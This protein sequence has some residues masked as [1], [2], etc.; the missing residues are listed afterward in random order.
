MAKPQKISDF[1]SLKGRLTFS[2]DSPVAKQAAAKA[3][4]KAPEVSKKEEKDRGL[5]VGQKVVL[6]DSDLRGRIVSLGRS[7]GIELEDGLTIQ[8]AYGEFAVYDEREI[9][10]LKQSKVKVGKTSQQPFHRGRA[11]FRLTFISR[12]FREAAAYPRGSSC[13]FRWTRSEGSSERTW[14]IGAGRY[15]SS[16]VSVTAY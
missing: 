16:M 9:S 12:R 14:P 15:A 11:C 4:V 10:A 3:D 7:V 2:D 6:M 5:K 13:S 8:T 1:T